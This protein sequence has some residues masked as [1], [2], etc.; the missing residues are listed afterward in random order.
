[1]SARVGAL[2]HP[3]ATHAVDA[4]HTRGPS[5]P[6]PCAQIKAAANVDRR[7]KW[8]TEIHQGNRCCA[9]WDKNATDETE[10]CSKSNCRML[11]CI[12]IRFK[13]PEAMRG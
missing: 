12:A 1:M 13:V 6:P 10:K 2:A 8:V 5:P 9:L 4:T 3:T 11:P 7:A